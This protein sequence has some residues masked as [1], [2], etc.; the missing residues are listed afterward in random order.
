MKLVIAGN[1]VGSVTLIKELKKLNF[2]AKIDV[3]TD[4]KRPFY[5]RPRLIEVLANEATIKDI[6]PYNEK[7]YDSH[8]VKLHLSDPIVELNIND[9][10]ARSKAGKIMSYDAFIFANGS[11]CFVLPIK[12]NDLENI[13]TLRDYDDVENIKKHYGHSTKIVVIGG[14]ILGIEMAAALK[15]AGENEVS[16]VEFFPYLLPRQLDKQ[17]ATV[18]KKQLERSYG[19]N[20][21]LGKATAELGG[22][23]KVEKISFSD[24]T[25]INADVVI[26]SVGVRS[27]TNVAKKSGI[28]V[29]RGIVID[30]HLKTN[31]NGV[32]AVGDVAQYDNV[33][34][35]TVP[36][37]VEQARA[38]AGVL[39]SQNRTYTGSIMSNMLKVAGINLLSTGKTNPDD[40]NFRFASQGDMSR[41]IYK[42]VILE[43]G[44][45]VGSI[46]IGIKT[47]EALRMKKLVENGESIRSDILKY[48]EL[49]ELSEGGMI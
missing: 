37:S 18:L 20:F 39:A 45:F 26:F 44:R 21:L 4:E 42:K 22:E 29:E 14:G 30:E 5:W 38:L 13:Y 33:V 34:Y 23:K 46:A 41:G 11:K 35:G 7:W 32:Y 6:T 1:G 47:Q 2:D 36:P 8:N 28:K 17:A 19:I 9:K 40:G 16:V 12:G 24:K 43:K 3:F 27:N 49:A 48:V 10:K 25:S 15:Q 31:A